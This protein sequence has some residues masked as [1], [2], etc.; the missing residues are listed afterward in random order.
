MK[1]HKFCFY[2]IEQVGAKPNQTKRRHF[3]HS[4]ASCG[5]WADVR[6]L[7]RKELVA[8]NATSESISKVLTIGFNTQVL[9]RYAD[10]IVLD[11]SDKTYRIKTKP[12]E[13]NYSKGDIKMEIYEF[14]DNNVY[15]E[16]IYDDA[17]S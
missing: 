10:L 14:N 8:N 3:I 12:D 17:S 5:F 15:G 13:Y 1:Q 4:K 7:S 16:D 2:T 11:E 9:E 6:D